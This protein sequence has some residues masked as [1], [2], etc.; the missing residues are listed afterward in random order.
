MSLPLTVKPAAAPPPPPPPPWI[1]LPNSTTGTRY[2]NIATIYEN[3]L[4]SIAKILGAKSSLIK[5]S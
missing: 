5:I 2:E 4:S 1:A 3:F